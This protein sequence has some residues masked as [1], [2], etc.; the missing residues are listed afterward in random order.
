MIVTDRE[1]GLDP[2]R[3]CPSIASGQK[4]SKVQRAQRPQP[5]ATFMPRL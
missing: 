1:A 3:L 2:E 5:Q 4:L